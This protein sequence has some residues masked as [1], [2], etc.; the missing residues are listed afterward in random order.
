[1]NDI[2]RKIQAALQTNDD[3][4]DPSLSD[5]VVA[6]FRG[7][8]RGLSLL[9]IVLNVVIFGIAVFAGLRAHHAETT[10]AQIEWTALT[11]V[12]LMMSMMLKLWFWLEIH[13]HRVLREVKRLELRL[14]ERAR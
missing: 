8:H 12:L 5:D 3:A 13:T 4:G 9:T 11:L 7:R 14:V 1:M 6:A 10:S 2:D